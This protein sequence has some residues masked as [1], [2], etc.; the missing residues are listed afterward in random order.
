MEQGSEGSQHCNSHKVKAE[1]FSV[2]KTFFISICK[3]FQSRFSEEQERSLQRG[4]DALLQLW[5]GWKL[6]LLRHPSSLME[7]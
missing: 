7:P 2:G 1:P 6:I 5:R 3:A 4:S